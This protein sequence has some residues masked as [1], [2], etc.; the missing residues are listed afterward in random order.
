MEGRLRHAVGRE[1]HLRSELEAKDKELQRLQEDMKQAQ[2]SLSQ[3]QEEHQ[4]QQMEENAYG[5]RLAGMDATL[6]VAQQ[7]FEVE[8][9]QLRQQI[10]QQ[11]EMH[12]RQR[13]ECKEELFAVKRELLQAVEEGRGEMKAVEERLAKAEREVEFVLADKAELQRKWRER[14]RELQEEVDRQQK[15]VERVQ[16]EW[17]ESRKQSLRQHEEE[18]RLAVE[19]R[20]RVLLGKHQRLLENERN[21]VVSLQAA[22]EARRIVVQGLEQ[23][24]EE[25]TRLL[26]SLGDSKKRP[27][28]KETGV[29]VEKAVQHP[30]PPDGD[31]IVPLGRGGRA[32]SLVEFAEIETLLC[33]EQDFTRRLR[34]EIHETGIPLSPPPLLLPLWW[35]G[36]YLLFFGG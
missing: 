24:V 28:E 27:E 36:A 7:R 21:E 31:R 4:R 30:P 2:L 23:E 16:R 11:E 17:E 26:C 3:L 19:E 35:C 34:N 25:K 12:S 9:A 14:E 13:G 8:K 1:Q 32:S 6:E 5:E 22:L 20:E 18:I 10:A 15:E 33:R 29:G